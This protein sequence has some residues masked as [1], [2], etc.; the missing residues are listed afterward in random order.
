VSPPPPL[1]PVKV[2]APLQRAASSGI[3][4]GLN[5]LVHVHAEH[6]HGG[7]HATVHVHVGLAAEP[8]GRTTDA[9]GL[10]EPAAS[11]P[12]LRRQ[13][14]RKKKGENGGRQDMQIEP[15]PKGEGEEFP[16]G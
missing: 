3:R 10:Q 16:T 1:F 9:F 15:A 5:S 4:A 12:L 8:A 7:V 2:A 14:E 13:Q 6:V 11:A